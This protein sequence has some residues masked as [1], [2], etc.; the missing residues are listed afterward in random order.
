MSTKLDRLAIEEVSGV[1]DPANMI[2]GWLLMKSRDGSAG[3]RAYTPLELMAEVDRLLLA[4][5]ATDEIRGAVAQAMVEKHI[6]M[7][8]VAKGRGRGEVPEGIAAYEF[9][10]GVWFVAEDSDFFKS[11]RAEGDDAVVAHFE[12]NL[13]AFGVGL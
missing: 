10:G 2:R 4:D 5:G 3:A 9:D 6:E 8:S 12:E 7:E 11:L 1:D 13:R